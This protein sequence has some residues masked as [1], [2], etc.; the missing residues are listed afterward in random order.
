MSKINLDAIIP[1]KRIIKTGIAVAICLIVSEYFFH[2]ASYYMIIATILSMKET[3][4]QSLIYGSGRIKG[5]ILGGFVGMLVLF[6]FQYLGT[7]V[8]SSAYIIIN[9]FSAIFCIWVSKLLKFDENGGSMSCVVLFT[10][11]IVRFYEN[12][13]PYVISRVIE[14]L[15]GILIA[16]AVN[17]FT[18]QSD[19]RYK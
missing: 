13:I 9:T 14:T 18:F 4:S 11:T 17:T 7:S 19:V 1:G 2:D 5:T 6:L 15:I 12:I 10:I 8:H 3:S 16:I